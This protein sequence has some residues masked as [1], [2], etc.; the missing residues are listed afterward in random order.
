MLRHIMPALVAT[1][2]C[3]TSFA[4]AQAEFPSPSY[5]PQ[6]SAYYPYAYPYVHP[7]YS[8]TAA[9]G[10]LRGQADWMRGY[11]DMHRSLG[12]A[13][14]FY[15]TADH[16]RMRNR[17]YKIEQFWLNRRTYA[18][19]LRPYERRNQAVEVPSPNQPQ[20]RPSV[21]APLDQ[22]AG[23]SSIKPRHYSRWYVAGEITWPTTLKSVS[24]SQARRTLEHLVAQ[25]AAG[26]YV[27][28][29]VNIQDKIASTI[30]SML[31]ELKSRIKSIPTVEYVEARYLLLAVLERSNDSISATD[32]AN[33]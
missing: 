22:L 3:L 9:E 28:A 1:T 16:L 7:Y 12:E 23:T 4:N 17:Q 20:R 26:V 18:E 19:R 30:D 33:N 2:C 10:F 32:L 25:R 11:G 14:C 24:T 27:N 29:N 21:S 15:R 6:R 31:A 5:A 13:A 8:S